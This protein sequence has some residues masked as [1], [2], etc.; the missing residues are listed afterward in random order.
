M[1]V[2]YDLLLLDDTVCIRETHDN[3]ADDFN[4]WFTAF[5]A[6]QISVVVK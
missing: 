3:G 5:P 1:I 4:L 2:F 6:E